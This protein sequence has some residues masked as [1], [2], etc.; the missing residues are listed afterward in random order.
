VALVSTTTQRAGEGL[1]SRISYLFD[2]MRAL[3]ERLADARLTEVVMPLM[4]AGHGHIEK[5]LALVGL[6][7]AIAEVARYGQ[8]SQRLR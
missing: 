7:L 4:G 3:V 8:G 6:L 5:P 1:S 2:G